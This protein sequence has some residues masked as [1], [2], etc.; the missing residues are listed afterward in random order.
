MTVIRRLKT[1]ARADDDVAPPADAKP[2]T[3]QM[4]QF[5][6]RMRRRGKPYGWIARALGRT[7]ADCVERAMKAGL[8]AR[9]MP[10]SP[11][12][13]CGEPVAI[14]PI[15]EI[16]DEGVCHWISDEAGNGEWRMCG[17]PGIEESNWCAHHRRR[18]YQPSILAELSSPNRW[19]VR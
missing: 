4:L 14:G 15:K 8:L 7:R 13:V 12:V 17:H 10:S 2:W 18:V 6:L 9:Q 3:T 5:L 11:Q 19:I 1:S 16:L